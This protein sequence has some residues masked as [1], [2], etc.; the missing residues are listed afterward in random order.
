VV[1]VEQLYV[2]AQTVGANFT[3]GTVQIILECT[4]ETMTQ[5]QAMALAL[6][7]Q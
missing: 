3:G 7:Q 4:A 5:S 6:S 2:G 1:G